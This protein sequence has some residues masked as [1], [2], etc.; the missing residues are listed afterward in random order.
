MTD[1]TDGV[2]RNSA[3]SALFAI[4]A[5]RFA[6]TSENLYQQALAVESRGLVV[7]NRESLTELCGQ[8]AE[9]G[10]FGTEHERQAVHVLVRE[11]ALDLGIVPASIHSLYSAIGRDA[12]DQSF[13]VPAI[14][15]R[16]ISYNTARGIFQAIDDLAVGAMIFELSRGE[17][18]FTGQRPREYVTSVLCAAIREG[19][20]GPIFFQGDHFQISPSRYRE[21]AEGEVQAVEML[22]REAVAA[23]FYN[24]DVDTSTLVDLS[25]PTVSEQ[26][27]PNFELCAR[28]TQVCRNAEPDGIT[29]SVGGEIGEVG[30]HNTTIEEIDAFMRGFA[31]CLPSDT[32]G[33]SK[34]SVQTGTKHGGN[35]LADGR[36]GDMNLDFALLDRLGKACRE[37]HGLGGIVQHGASTLPLAKFSNFPKAR[38][39]E[40]HLAASFLNTIYDLLPNDLVRHADDWLKAEFADE[41]QP[42][43]SEQQFLYHARRYPIG[44]FKRQWWNVGKETLKDM[45]AAIRDQVR[46]Y[47]EAL[48]VSGTRTMIT[49]RVVQT[50]VRPAMDLGHEQPE[51]QQIAQDTV[52]RDLAS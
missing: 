10:A 30:E 12:V 38:C 43:M 23:G 21:D 8:F 9:L 26:Q 18:G 2:G 17:I 35:V 5:Q 41:W 51:H 42:G 29:I 48:G 31:A 6:G 52:I 25:R 16:A 24:I 49:E 44:P 14:N 20:S 50:P 27:R 7:R 40:V 32:V 13:T 36:L 46:S 33:L 22:I 28:L 1:Q 3:S 47:F 15:V 39:L 34:L 11:A 4:L 45:R 19:Y 37:R